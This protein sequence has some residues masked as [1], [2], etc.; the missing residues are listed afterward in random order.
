MFLTVSAARRKLMR[1]TNTVDFTYHLTGFSWL[2][3]T[4][5]AAVSFH[6]WT[7]VM[8]GVTDRELGHMLQHQSPEAQYQQKQ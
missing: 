1:Q 4:S 5:Q 8:Y 3:C 6:V 2:R 7:H